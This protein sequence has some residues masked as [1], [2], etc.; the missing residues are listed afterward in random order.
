M[1]L[2]GGSQTLF[3]WAGVCM[4][5]SGFQQPHP[6]TA[7]Y[8]EFLSQAFPCKISQLYP[9]KLPQRTSL[10]HNVH[11]YQ[12]RH[13]GPLNS[14]VWLFDVADTIFCWKV[15]QMTTERHKRCQTRH[16]TIKKTCKMTKQPQ[17]EAKWPPRDAKRPQR[18]TKQP[19]RDAKWPQRDKKWQQI[20]VKWPQRSMNQPPKWS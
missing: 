15:N 3:H 17:R 6:L 16:K 4:V 13:R 14:W 20:D 12:I 10:K 19:Q 9:N 8:G 7:S 5:V 18:D 1:R 2:L 11:K